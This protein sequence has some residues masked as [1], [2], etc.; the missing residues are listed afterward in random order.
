MFLLPSFIIPQEKTKVNACRE[1]FIFQRET[2][3]RQIWKEKENNCFTIDSKPSTFK[4]Y[5]GYITVS[6]K[7]E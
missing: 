1:E 4:I 3:N 5:N 2:L 7:K 6:D